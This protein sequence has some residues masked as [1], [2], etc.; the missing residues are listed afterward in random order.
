[1][2]QGFGKLSYL[3]ETPVEQVK[4][5]YVLPVDRIP[6]DRWPLRLTQVKETA[7]GDTRDQL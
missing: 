4:G 6:M 5:A 1:M 7:A 3:Q 2:I